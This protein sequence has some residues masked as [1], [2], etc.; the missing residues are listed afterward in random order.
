MVLSLWLSSQYSQFLLKTVPTCQKS[1]A[2]TV[3]QAP[4]WFRKTRWNVEKKKIKKEKLMFFIIDCTNNVPAPSLFSNSS[5]ADWRN[6]WLLKI[7]GRTS[8]SSVKLTMKHSLDRDNCKPFNSWV[9]FGRVGKEGG[10]RYIGCTV[11]NCKMFFN[12]LLA[13]KK[14]TLFQC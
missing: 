7:F 5:K 14:K 4:T 9:C 11:D 1:P 8:P 3:T 2:A 13:R 12:L 6:G 10:S